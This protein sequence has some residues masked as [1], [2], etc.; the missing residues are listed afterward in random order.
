MN[1]LRAIGRELVAAW[2]S[3]RYDLRQLVRRPGPGGH[4][5]ARRHRAGDRA[6]GPFPEYRAYLRQPRKLRTAVL[7]ATV[8]V[9]GTALAYLAVL[10]GLAALPAPAVTPLDALPEF[11]VELT[12]PANPDPGPVLAD[13]P[14]VSPPPAPGQRWSPPP[15]P[16]PSAPASAPATTVAPS[17]IPIAPVP[18]TS[19]P[20]TATP[21]P[22]PD[23]DPSPSPTEEATPDPDPSPSP[24]TEPDRPGHRAATPAS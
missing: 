11:Q 1:I 9:G 24:P 5:W 10:G 3:V 23:P 12:S 21:E 20:E 8:T 17:P 18:P 13:P 16:E 14:A 19:P 2:R 22:T 7:V 15:T 6:T 4:R